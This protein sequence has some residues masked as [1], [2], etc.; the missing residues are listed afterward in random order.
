MIDE[1]FIQSQKK[2]IEQKITELEVEVSESR[3]YKDLGSSDDDKTQEFEKFEE[4]NAIARAAQKELEDLK[5]AL[6]RIE[7]EKYGYCVKCDQ[8]IE[9]GRLKGYLGV[10]YCSTHARK[11]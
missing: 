2:L 10:I 7:D 9:R 5:C 11:V 1:K 4:D 6:Q 8:P 3:K